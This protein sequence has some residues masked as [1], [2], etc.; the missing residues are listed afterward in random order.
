[1]TMS[2]KD[3]YEASLLL[4]QGKNLLRI[5][6]ETT[7]FFRNKSSLTFFF[8]FDSAKDCEKILASYYRHEIKIDAFAFAEAHTS[9]KA[10]IRALRRA[11]G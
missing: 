3:L 4:T 7:P 10:K 1:M 8:V 2:I 11:H 9:L 6:S 5:D